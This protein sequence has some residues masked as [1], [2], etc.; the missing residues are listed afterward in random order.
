MYHDKVQRKC[1]ENSEEED[2]FLLG[3]VVGGWRG[4]RRGD[5]TVKGVGFELNRGR[6]QRRGAWWSACVWS[7]L[8]RRWATDGRSPGLSSWVQ[9]HRFTPPLLLLP[10]ALRGKQEMFCLEASEDK[11]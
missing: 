3:R 1:S 7:K 2:Y 6:D 9:F 8:G 4:S 5:I 11:D 10:S